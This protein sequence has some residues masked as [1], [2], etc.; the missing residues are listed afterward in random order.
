MKIKDDYIY[1]VGSLNDDAII[2]RYNMDLTLYNMYTFGG[3]QYEEFCKV[4]FI[5]D[6]IYLFGLKMELVIIVHF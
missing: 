5:D 1:L 3:E 4:Y 2:Y 6:A